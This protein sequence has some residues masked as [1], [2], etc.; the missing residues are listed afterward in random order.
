MVTSMPAQVADCPFCD[1]DAF[2]TSEC[3]IE[4]RFCAY[5]WDDTTGVLPGAGIIIP[6]AHRR[7]PFELT[8]A[9][10][11]ATR[12]LLLVAQDRIARRWQADGYT[13][14]WN[15]GSAAGQEVEHAHFHVIPRF[16]D[17]PHAGHGIRWA[18]KG[19]Q[20]R[21]PDPT[22]TGHGPASSPYA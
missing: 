15:C 7:T 12:T 3:F 18:I 22:A 6:I 14:G 19:E 8:P 20:N 10:W 13:L 21:R 11:I 17:E 16:A 2:R 9:E 5:A 1:L 4:D